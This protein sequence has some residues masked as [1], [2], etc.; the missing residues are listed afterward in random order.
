MNKAQKQKK[1]EHSS[2]KKYVLIAGVFVL[3]ALVLKRD[4]H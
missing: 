1:P 3:C 2:K 4:A